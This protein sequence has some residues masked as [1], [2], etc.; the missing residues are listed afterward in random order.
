[1]S[2]VPEPKCWCGSDLPLVAFSTEYVRCPD[3]QTLVSTGRLSDAEL[4]VQ[5]DETSF[6]GKSYWLEHQ[7]DDYGH[8]R[9]EDRARLDLRERCLHWLQTL[10]KYR[11][12]PA[13]V[14]ELGA[15]HGG[16]VALM[17]QA[18]FDA[19]GLEL[20]PWVVDFARDTFAVPMVRGPIED[21]ALEQGS[22][23]VIVLMDVL[24]HLSHPEETL[25]HCFRLLKPGGVLLVQTPCYRYES[26]EQLVASANP[27]LRMLRA[28]EHLYL[29]SE[30]SLRLIMGRLGGWEVLLEPSLFPYDLFAVVSRRELVPQ[31]SKVL[32]AALER[33]RDGRMTAALLH[34]YARA[35]YLQAE[36][37]KRLAV[38]EA[39]DGELKCHRQTRNS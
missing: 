8:P 34:L 7:K 16:F 3:C 11:L 22:L 25:T 12:P 15:S 32:E 2:A 24:E 36:C 26:H 9:I 38:I 30:K 39:L 33:S 20:S 4:T 5:D 27:F 17:R 1:M 19:S 37:D 13:R 10:L 31:D 21:Q 35:E 28:K 18:G 6:Y 23:D 29:F 14:L